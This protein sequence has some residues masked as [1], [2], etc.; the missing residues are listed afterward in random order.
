MALPGIEI[1]DQ[2]SGTRLLTAWLACGPWRLISDVRH[3]IPLACA[4]LAA[5]VG[6]VPPGKRLVSPPRERI[7]NIPVAVLLTTAALVI[8]HLFMALLS[9]PEWDDALLVFGFIPARYDPLF[10]ASEP[11]WER[12][13][14][15]FPIYGVAGGDSPLWS[16]I[17]P[18]LPGVLMAF[19]REYA[20]L[21]ST[22]KPS[23]RLKLCPRNSSPLAHPAERIRKGREALRKA[24]KRGSNKSVKTWK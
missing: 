15:D 13:R 8:V 9:E 17:E 4:L 1:R 7:F 19:C 2:S 23:W 24:R 5:Y 21:P 22:Q 11:W 12:V 3:L 16:L 6:P 20:Q 10:L 14:R 18:F